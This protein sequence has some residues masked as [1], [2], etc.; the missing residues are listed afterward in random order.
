MDR[1]RILG[2]AAVVAVA[3]MLSASGWA[4][5]GRVRPASMRRGDEG[6]P[7]KGIVG[8][9][10][11]AGK[12][13]T[14]VNLIIVADLLEPLRDGGPFTVFAPTDEAFA[15][16]PEGTIEGLLKP[17]NKEAL[18]ELLAYHVVPGKILSKDIGEKARAKTLAGPSLTLGAS[19]SGVFHR[20]CS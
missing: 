20:M 3:G 17:E 6:K 12:F 11:Q 5:E 7:Q 19:G 13:R 10:A 8:T 9:A 14:L 4:G 1:K 15:K 2:L 16:L 18:K